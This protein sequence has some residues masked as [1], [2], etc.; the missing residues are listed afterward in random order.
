MDKEFFSIKKSFSWYGSFFLPV[1]PF[2]FWTCY[3]FGDK[4]HECETVSTWSSAWFQMFGL[5]IP[6]YPL[7]IYPDMF[8]SLFEPYFELAEDTNIENLS[9]LSWQQKMKGQLKWDYSNGFQLPS[10]VRYHLLSVSLWVLFLTCSLYL[11]FK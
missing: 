7:K 1:F 10:I 2:A 9:F 3:E 6:R 8:V 11:L 5:K 4:I